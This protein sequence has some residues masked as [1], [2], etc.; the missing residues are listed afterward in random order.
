MDVERLKQDIV[1][2]IDIQKFYEAWMKGEHIAPGSGGWSKRVRCPFH[3]D[4]DTPNFFVSLRAGTFKCHACSEGGSIFD[5]W[6][7]MNGKDKSEFNDS[8]VALANVA[9]IDIGSWR[10][11]QGSSSKISADRRAAA[12]EAKPEV[13]KETTEVE[14]DKTKPPISKDYVIRLHRALTPD[15]VDF[16]V[17]SRGLTRKTI[18]GCFIGWDES[19]PRKDRGNRIASGRISIPVPNVD[20]QFRN[21]RGYSNDT[22]PAFK[23]V[24]FIENRKQPNELSRGKPP[25]LYNVHRMIDEGWTNV[26]ICEGEF[27]AILLTQELHDAGYTD[28]GAVTPT[29]GVSNFQSWWVDMLV[30]RNVYLCFDVDS[31][32]KIGAAKVAT[33]HFLPG[34]KLGR[35]NSVKIIELPRLS[36]SKEENDITDFFMKKNGTAEEFIKAAT[37][38]LPLISGGFDGDDASVEPIEVEDFVSLLQKREYID[39]RVRVPIAIT[40]QTSKLYHAIRE[41][42]VEFCPNRGGDKEC[43]TESGQTHTIPYGHPAYIT[44][45]MNS[46]RV[47][48]QELASL[49]CN[50]GQCRK[51]KIKARSKVVIELYYAHQVVDRWRVS[52]EDGRLVNKQELKVAPIYI[53]QPPE[54]HAVQPTNY[55]AIGWVRTHPQTGMSCLFVES[56]EKI[57]D[58]WSKFDSTL[59]EN[60]EHLKGL[61]EIGRDKI[62]EAIINDVTRIY[63]ADEILYTVLLTYLCPLRLHFNGEIQRGWIN[64]AIIGDTGTGKSATFNKFADWVSVGSSFSALSGSRTGLLYAIK[65]SGGG[66]W[67]LSIGLYVR[68]DGQIL[69]IDEVQELESDEIKKM[70]IAM[71]TG[72]LDIERVV[73]GGYPTRTRTIFILNPKNSRGQAVT[74]SDFPHGCESIRHCFDPMFIR[75]LDFAVFTTGNHAPEFYNRR[76]DSPVNSVNKGDKKKVNLSAASFRSLIFWAWTRSPKQIKFTDD[77]TDLCLDAATRLSTRYGHADHVPLAKAQDLRLK[78][79]RISAAFAVLSCSFSEDFQGLIVLP[80]HVKSSAM[81]LDVVYSSSAC[82]LD[83][84]SSR[85]QETHVLNDYTGVA[86]SIDAAIMSDDTS[87]GMSSIPKR[88]FLQLMLMI[89]RLDSIRRNDILS[90]L[91]VRHDWLRA[92]LAMLM[93]LNLIEDSKYGIQK[94]RKWNLFIR[95][96]RSEAPEKYRAMNDLHLEMAKNAAMV[97]DISGFDEGPGV[98]EN[99]SSYRDDMNS[100]GGFGEEPKWI[101]AGNDT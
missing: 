68:S 56:M 88:N 74:V 29:H 7:K 36:G 3:D 11:D 33:E 22:D 23:I 57:E 6:L 37:E 39:Q 15:V 64:S 61:K 54:T 59:P 67:Q 48:H 25:R 100:S 77:A 99:E 45:C 20:G 13:N 82:E 46:E 65:Q 1:A 66:E 79:A 49:L 17:K 62:V 4:S 14:F 76:V 91:G 5:F 27:D 90:R 83:A 42:E 43:C 41:C 34:I 53:L 78:V 26:V 9:G 18:E 55:M 51:L 60:I 84:T 58:D 31:A 95:Q 98:D 47:V 97:Q 32:G 52:E 38:S 2:S 50:K 35:F 75:R 28:W 89:D 93:G 73:T 70:A 94:T 30:S 80:E 40:G 21:I 86:E 71:D 96:W 19:W 101:G 12:A 92:K 87:S 81:F 69:A 24:N 44:S 85:G 10:K 63:E 16:L 72:Y 8:L